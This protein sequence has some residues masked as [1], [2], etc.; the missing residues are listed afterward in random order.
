MSPV[1][2]LDDL[3]VEDCHTMGRIESAELPV[4]QQ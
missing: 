4:D 2:I 3:A 1:Y